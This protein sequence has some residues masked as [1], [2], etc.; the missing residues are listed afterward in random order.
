MKITKIEITDDAKVTIL[1]EGKTYV[2]VY[3][4]DLREDSH[5]SAVLQALAQAVEQRVRELSAGIVVKTI[6]E[7]A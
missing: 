3:P 2:G 4:Y 5:E 1:D 7:F 6:V